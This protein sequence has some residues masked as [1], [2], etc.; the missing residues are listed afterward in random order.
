MTESYLHILVEAKKEYTAQLTSILTSPMYEGISSIYKHAKTTTKNDNLLMN[1]QE[2][3]SKIPKW[4]N[5]M[6]ERE[7]QRIMLYSRCDW[8]SDL[9]T[10]VFISHTKVLSSIHLGNSHK[11]IDLKIPTPIRFIHMVYINI[12]REFWKNPYLLYDIGVSSAEAQRNLRDSEAVIKECIHNSIRKLLPVRH[13]IK[14]YLGERDTG[15]IYTE[16]ITSTLSNVHIE[17]IKKM[18]AVDMKTMNI[19]NKPEDYTNHIVDDDVESVLTVQ[20]V[21]TGGGLNLEES[22]NNYS[23]ENVIVNQDDIKNS[24][25]VNKD[26]IKEEQ[27]IELGL[28]KIDDDNETNE[29]VAETASIGTSNYSTISKRLRLIRTHD[30]PRQKKSTSNTIF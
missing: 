5:D 19:D 17:Q 21:G 16:D 4:N 12:A 6:L 10:A 18:V 28:D 25:V 3:L 30:R 22:F 15:S 8:I 29:E 7:F 2:L 14:E 23:A 13:I 9:I 20:A 11:D 24:T 1:F 27:N 26:P